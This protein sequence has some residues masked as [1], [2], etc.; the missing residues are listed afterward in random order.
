MVD[1]RSAYRVLVGI[2][3]GKKPFGSLRYIQQ[4]NIKMDLQEVS[5]GGKDCIALAQERDRWQVNVNEVM[6]TLLPQKA[7]CLPN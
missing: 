6:I 7:G 3:E 5:W 1:K 2:P 4:D